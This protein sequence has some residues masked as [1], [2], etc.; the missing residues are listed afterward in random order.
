MA[1]TITFRTD[2]D[3]ERA[4]A[5]LTADGTRPSDAVRTALIETAAR[6]ARDRLRA[7]VAALADDPDDLRE[8]A[9]VLRDMESLSAG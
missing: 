5:E 2:E 6:R 7:E 3:S 1:G 4:L 8:A 9:Q